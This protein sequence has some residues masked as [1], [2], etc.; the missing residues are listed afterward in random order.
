MNKP[1]KAPEAR[2]ENA[3]VWVQLRVRPSDKARWEAQAKREGMSLT[4]W[5]IDR[6]NRIVATERAS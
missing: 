1:T 3:S 2:K 4:K 5:V 6:A